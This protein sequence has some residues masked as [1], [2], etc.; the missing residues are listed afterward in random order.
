MHHRNIPRISGV[1]PSIEPI[2]SNCGTTAVGTIL[3]MRVG[4][5]MSSPSASSLVRPLMTG[6]HEDL[7]T[8]QAALAWL[9]PHCPRCGRADFTPL[10]WYEAVIWFQCARC[11]KL[12]REIVEEL[13]VA[14]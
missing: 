2:H 10:T 14:G 12:W 5:T 7:R 1:R 11:Y 13:P 3:A 6:T 8:V 9:R 4:Y